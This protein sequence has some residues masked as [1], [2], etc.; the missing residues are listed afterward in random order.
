M[1]YYC[2]C[3]TEDELKRIISEKRKKFTPSHF[4]R[5]PSDLVETDKI[6]QK[7]NKEVPDL[8]KGKKIKK[9][10]QYCTYEPNIILRT[11]F[12]LWQKL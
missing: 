2:L 8:K 10:I 6:V 7:E 9:V 3:N 5:A 1:K 12:L 4:L 11:V